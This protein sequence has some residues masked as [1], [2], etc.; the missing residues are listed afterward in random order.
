MQN[1]GL[2][3][4]LYLI[5]PIQIIESKENIMIRM[6]KISAAMVVLIL[7]AAP[8][9][10]DDNNPLKIE[11]VS[12]QYVSFVDSGPQVSPGK[13]FELNLNDPIIKN[14]ES[15]RINMVSERKQK[16]MELYRYTEN[17]SDHMHAVQ[18]GYV[19]W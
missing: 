7:F 10:A 18:Q 13:N 4:M 11:T 17:P 12:Y 16:N 14:P 8:S 15:E 6:L 3:L 1:V 9:F 2:I 19:P 5:L